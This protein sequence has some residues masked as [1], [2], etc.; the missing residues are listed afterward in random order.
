[1]IKGCKMK[2]NDFYLFYLFSEETSHSGLIKP[3]G[4]AVKS[5]RRIDS[6]KIR[7]V[8]KGPKSQ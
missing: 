3:R 5:T 6:D 8:R 2:E 4:D 1:M 7:R